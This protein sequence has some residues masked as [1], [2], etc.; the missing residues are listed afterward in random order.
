MKK[1]IAF[2]LALIVSIAEAK[3]ISGRVTKDDKGIGG[4]FV[5]AH[6]LENRKST[7]VFTSRDGSFSI[8]GLRDNSHKVRARLMGLN[9]VW[10][11]DIAAGAKSVTIK[12]TPATG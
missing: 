5:S 8:T 1:T 12:M 2:A 11:E 6:D 10:L 3:T 9:D 7:G 4:V